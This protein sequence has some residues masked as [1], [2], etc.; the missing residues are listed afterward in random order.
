MSSGDR[1]NPLSELI[2]LAH[3]RVLAQTGSRL[4][5]VQE[6]ILEQVLA[7]KKLKHIQVPGYGDLTVQRHFCPKLWRLFSESFGQTVRL[8][9]VRLTLEKAMRETQNSISFVAPTFAPSSSASLESKSI[10]NLPAPSCTTFIGR[11]TELTRLLDLLSPR[12]AAHLISVDG[13]GGVGKTTLVVEAAY[14]C[15]QSSQSDPSNSTV[16]IFDIIIFTSAKELRLTPLGF[17]KC[18]SPR[19]TL[20][21]LFCQIARVVN[22]LEITGISFAEQ[23]DRI[24]D[25]LAKYRTLLIVDNLET[26]TDQEDVLAFLYELPPT[27]KAV[28]TTREQIIFVPV[29]LTSMPEQD[30]LSLIQQEAQEKGVSLSDSDRLN[31]YQAT[32][33]IPVAISYAIGQ[34]ANGFL[35]QEVLQKIAHPKGNVSRF[36]FETSVQSFR[37]QPAH[38]L[39]MALALFP[40]SADQDAL[41]QVATPHIDPD[42][43]QQD[44]ARL[45]GLSLVKQDHH[46]YSMLPLTREYALAELKADPDFAQE[47]RQRWLDWYLDFSTLYARFDHGEWL[48]LGFEELEVEWQNLQAVM[49]WCMAVG[50]DTKAVQLWQNLRNYTQV[51][52]R[53]ISRLGCWSDRLTWTAWLMDIAEQRGDWQTFAQMTLDHT[54]TLTALGKSAQLEIAE[55]LLLRVWELRHHQDLRFQVTLTQAIVVL[56][57]QQQ[58][59]EEAQLWLGQAEQILQQTD[60][61]DSDQI[62]Q[63]IQIDYY[64]GEI[65]FKSGDYEL[66]K[67]RF[68]S[69]LNAARQIDWIRAIFIIQNWLAEIAIFQGQIDQAQHLLMD[70]L[71][72]AEANQDRTRKAYC[73]RSLAKLSLAQGNQAEAMTW[74]KEALTTFEALGMIQ[75]A[76]E[77][78]SLL[79]LAVRSHSKQEENHP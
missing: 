7:G 33:G 51:R 57:I 74:A 24:Q 72:V 38:H 15:L 47:V 11:E 4:T 23:L 14:R 55:A 10:H 13:I 78:Q 29:R 69:A 36:C 17:L 21:D 71:Q 39:L 25:T 76:E 44:L 16:P 52:G 54:W 65:L 61:E 5:D 45:R 48:G 62:R 26:V 22:E 59:F 68:A 32:G 66:A 18:Q 37:N 60:L 8:N 34:L 30:G 49:E 63:R 28:I 3:N 27:V 70:G 6:R 1:S 67:A 41:V 42:S 75:E 9:T 64:R 56:L 2:S 31:L 35:M 46:R 43:I 79:S 58:Q 12:S 77:T 40:S 53:H 19:R 73:Q 50:D 20:N